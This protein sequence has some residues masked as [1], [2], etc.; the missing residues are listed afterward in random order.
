MNVRIEVVC[1]SA[2][3]S[4]QRRQML[5]IER[6]ELAME[7]LGM[8]LAES[9]A[10]LAGVQDFM[11]AQQ[12]SENLEQ[13][14]ACRHCGRRHTTKDSGSTPVKTLFGS[15]NVL[16]PRW[17][18]CACQTQGPETFR[19]TAPWLQG[20]TSVEMLYL[21]SKWASLI[22][23]AKVADLLREVLPIGDSANHESVRIHLQATAERIEQE[24]G[25]ERQL[26]EYE[27]SEDD[28]EQQPLPDGPI[29]VGIDG[30]YVRAA[31]KQ[32]CFEVIAGKSVVAFRREDATEVPSAK[33]FGFVQTYDEKP[34]RRLWELM[35]SQGMQENQQVVFMSDGGEDVRRVQQYLH[36]FSEHLL[37]WFHITMRLTVLQQQTKGLQQERPETGADVAKQLESIK[38]LLWHGN[39]PEALERI[40]GLSIDLSLIQAHSVPAAKVA[41]GLA[42]FEIYIK[43]NCDVIPNFG[44]RWRQGERI[45]TAFVESTINQVV[46]RRFVKKQRMQWT[47]RGA[48]LLLQAWTK[49][50]NDELEGV[51]R[52]WYPRFRPQAA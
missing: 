40:T 21:E 17:N 30:G 19:P 46:S 41:N 32:G 18:R 35:K 31:H 29:T 38:H 20:R 7:T 25:R 36:P 12:V 27:G 50:L 23:F 49:V 51:F 43:N 45:S 24:L 10:L 15:V 8:S 9:K 2:D 26:N 14:R 39:T 47:H 52:R 37:D 16:N 28:W 4:E 3:G 34:R 6:Q 48:H 13:R 42:E 1:V 22:P 11:V 44:E 33:C 5:G